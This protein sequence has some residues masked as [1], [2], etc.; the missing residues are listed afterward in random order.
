MVTMGHMLADKGMCF[1]PYFGCLGGGEEWG[2]GIIREC[3]MHM[4]DQQGPTVQHRELSSMLCGSL[5]GRRVW[6]K[7]DTC[8]CM[9]ESLCHAPETITT[10][11]I[12]HCCLVAKSCSTLC[13]PRDCS[14]PGSSVQGILQA[15]TLEWVAMPSSRGS[16]QPRDQ[17][18][19][20]YVSYTGRQI[21]YH[22]H[23]LGSLEFFF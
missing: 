19:V 15:R 4:Y 5:E 8:V 17:T 11:L 22:E 10:L 1:F 20:S 21:L 18:H 3:V 23:H 2:E 12:G 7:T 13:D 16:S 6:R 14:L 9:A